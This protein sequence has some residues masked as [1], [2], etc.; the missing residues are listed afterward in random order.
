MIDEREKQSQKPQ[1]LV[2]VPLGEAGNSRIAVSEAGSVNSRSRGNAR[3]AVVN[4]TSR[5]GSG[6]ELYRSPPLYFARREG[7]D[8]RC[9]A[10]Q[11][12]AKKCLF[13]FLLRILYITLSSISTPNVTARDQQYGGT[14]LALARALSIFSL[15][16]DAH[17]TFFVEG[18]ACQ[19]EVC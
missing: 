15:R 11:K 13:M 17:V 4:R 19:K 3:F 14:Y 5:R 9:W 8:L 16:E 7:G 2:S 12:F 10:Q 6:A 1:G 18:H